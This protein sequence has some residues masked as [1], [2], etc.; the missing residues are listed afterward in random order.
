MSIKTGIHV[1]NYKSFGPTGGGIPEIKNVNIIVGKN[2][3]GKSSFIDVI[4]HLLDFETESPLEESDILITARLTTDLLYSVLK[5]TEHEDKINDFINTTSDNMSTVSVTWRHTPR[6]RYIGYTTPEFDSSIVQNIKRLI[7]QIPTRLGYQRHVRLMA[8]RDIR[9]EKGIDDCLIDRKLILKGD[10][11]GATQVIQ[12]LIHN[13][14][15]HRHLITD[16]LLKALNEVFLGN[17]KFTE[18]TAL[19]NTQTDLWEIYLS[20]ENKKPHALSKSGSGLKTVILLLI[21][22][23]IRPVLEG[24]SHSDY[25]FSAEEIEN[26]LHPSLQRSLF[27]YIEKFAVEHETHIF[28]TSH[29][30]VAIDVFSA[31]KN[32]QICHLKKSEDGVVSSIFQ[33]TSHGYNIL[34]D[35]GI[36]ASDI[37]QSNGII[38]VEGPSDRYFINKFI[39]LWSETLREGAHYQF[40]YYGGSI[41]TNYEASIPE[42]SFDQ[43]LNVFRINKNFIFICDSD[44]KAKTDPLKPRVDKLIS[45]L[46]QSNG[47]VWVTEAREIEN[48]VP[49]DAFSS[50]HNHAFSTEISEFDYIQSHIN[51]EIGTTA[52]KYTDKVNKSA[53]YTEHFTLKNL[54]FR[55][56]L[57]EVMKKICSTIEKWNHMESTV[58]TDHTD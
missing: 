49:K 40:G 39:A 57:D 17:A 43:A 47:Y 37:L 9:P 20:E 29:S 53:L 25:F 30:H 44:K 33:S 18:I 35:L 6:Q 46:K 58:K 14:H 50:V 22:I 24:K 32:A 31:S 36:R 42:S 19:R 48:Y 10:G 54:S 3:I 26:N 8:E 56:E 16:V 34:D 41:L 11:T 2:N 55:P 1:R 7:N 15:E 27:L 28:I 4:D 13:V 38:W 12:A 21:N 52:E 45:Q 5:S 23:L 51:S